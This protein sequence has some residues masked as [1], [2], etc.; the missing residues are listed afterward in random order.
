[1]TQAKLAAPPCGTNASRGWGR[2]ERFEKL[3]LNWVRPRMLIRNRHRASGSATKR[4]MA[5]LL[6]VSTS[7]CEDSVRDQTVLPGVA[8]N[9]R[10]EQPHRQECGDNPKDG[11]LVAGLFQGQGQRADVPAEERLGGGM[12]HGDA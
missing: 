7:F 4:A 2:A 5:P 3:V 1:M 8:Q 6:W 11:G 10:Y 9:H 12:R